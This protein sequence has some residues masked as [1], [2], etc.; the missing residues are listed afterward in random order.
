MAV[1]SAA[2]LVDQAITESQFL[3][4]A[5]LCI[6]D[7]YELEVRKYAGHSPGGQQWQVRAY[8]QPSGRK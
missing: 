5:E 4:F 1:G 8:H 3:T 7:I 6:E 2:Y